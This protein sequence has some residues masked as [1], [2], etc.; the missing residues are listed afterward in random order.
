MSHQ[1]GERSGVRLGRLLELR[2]RGNQPPGGVLPEEMVQRDEVWSHATLAHSGGTKDVPA[3]RGPGASRRGAEPTSGAQAAWLRPRSGVQRR[4]G[5]RM[6][7]S[8]SESMRVG[9][10]S[11]D[12]MKG[13]RG[14]VRYL[15]QGVHQGRDQGRIRSASTGGLIR[16]SMKECD[17]HW[18]IIMGNEETN[19]KYK[20]DKYSETQRGEGGERGEGRGG[21]KR[22][23]RRRSIPQSL[24]AGHGTWRL[25]MRGLREWQ[26]C[27]KGNDKKMID[28][29]K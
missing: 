27:G 14:L 7:A 11:V 16:A 19:T 12:R 21:R 20:K 15:H 4:D 13:Q 8:L 1:G 22:G 18:S 26:G 25:S 23:G 29:K 5:G 28:H 6:V 3:S 24:R 2:P 10:T 9:R 17:A